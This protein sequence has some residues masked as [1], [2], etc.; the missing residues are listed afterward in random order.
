MLEFV[1]S[2][3]KTLKLEPKIYLFYA[4]NFRFKKKK[5]NLL[6]NLILCQIV[7]I[8]TS[9]YKKKILRSKF[10][11]T[12]ILTLSF[13]LSMTSSVKILIADVDFPILWKII[14]NFNFYSVSFILFMNFFLSSLFITA[15]VSEI[16]HWQ[17]E[18]WQW[19]PPKSFHLVKV[20]FTFLF[21]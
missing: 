7:Y 13:I 20:L 4:D 1:Y 19:P 11:T 21:F 6:K 18:H 8:Y 5:E 15:L 14:V 2:Q 16:E 10:V 3:I 12:A 17:I 9:Y